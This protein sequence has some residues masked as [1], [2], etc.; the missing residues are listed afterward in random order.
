MDNTVIRPSTRRKPGEFLENLTEQLAILKE[1]APC[2]QKAFAGEPWYEVSR[3]TNCIRGFSAEKVGQNC[4]GCGVI[5]TTEAYPANELIDSIS[6]KI[7]ARPSVVYI[8]RGPDGAIELGAIAFESNPIAIYESSY[9][10][11]KD[12]HPPLLDAL[13]EKLPQHTIWL[14]EILA[15]LEKQ[16][17]GNLAHFEEMCEKI[18]DLLEPAVIGFRSINKGLVNKASRV[19]GERCSVFPVADCG[20]QSG[21]S[22]LVTIQAI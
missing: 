18:F 10:Q 15:D 2:Y 13:S 7:I 11:S 5:L 14:D 21:V 20:V 17:S 4:K 8:E 12:T 19:F 6:K 1:L 16:S 22:F 3:C 9:K